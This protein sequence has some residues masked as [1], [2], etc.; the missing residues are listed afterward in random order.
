MTHNTLWIQPPL[1]ALCKALQHAKPTLWLCPTAHAANMAAQQTAALDVDAMLCPPNFFTPDDPKSL[2]LYGQQ[3]RA[4]QNRKAIVDGQT[5][6]GPLPPTTLPAL[7]ITVGMAQERLIAALEAANY[8]AVDLVRAP[9]TWSLRTT[10]IDLYNPCYPW[11]VRCELFDGEVEHIRY[12]NPNH[13][14]SLPESPTSFFLHTLAPPTLQHGWFAQR[15]RWITMDLDQLEDDTWPPEAVAQ[16]HNGDNLFTLSHPL[17]QCY[18]HSTLVGTSATL[19]TL[20]TTLTATLSTPP[21]VTLTKQRV[22]G[23]DAPYEPPRFELQKGDYAVHEQAGIGKYE[24]LV[25]HT[26]H[27]GKEREFLQLT[28]AQGATLYVP[29]SQSHLVTKYGDSQQPVV[30]EGI[31]SKNWKKKSARA[32]SAITKYAHTLIHTYAQRAHYGGLR[33]GK[34]DSESAAL[35]DRTR[36]FALTPDQATAIAAIG[37]DLASDVAMDRLLCGDVGYGKTE[38]AIAA[39][40]QACNAGKQV[41]FLAP[42]ALLAL[43]HYE[44]LLERL[45]PFPFK[46]AHLSKLAKHEQA[47]MAQIRAGAIDIVVGTH[48]LLHHFV[49]CPSLA[50]VIIDEEQRFGVKAKETFRQ[51][52]PHLHYLALSATP[53]PRTLRFAMSGVRTLSSLTTPPANR[54]PVSVFVQQ[55]NPDMIAQALLREKSRLGRSF[56][57]CNSIDHL[58]R[59]ARWCEEQGLTSVIAHGQMP[60]AQMERAF[61][62][63]AKGDVD[64]LIATTVIE[65]GIDIPQA[66][67]IIV[68]GAQRFGL[69]E[70]YQIKGRVGRSSH[71]G[72]AYFFTPPKI[73]PLAQERLDALIAASLHGGGMQIAL[74]DLQLRGAGDFLGERQ[75]GHMHTIGFPLY[76]QWLKREMAALKEDTSRTNPQVE[77]PQAAHFPHHYLPHGALRM[78]LYHRLGLCDTLTQVQQ[79]FEE[80]VDRFGALPLEAKWLFALTQFRL[81][82]QRKGYQSAKAYA[83]QGQ[84]IWHLE[85]AIGCSTIRKTH[86]TPPLTHPEQLLQFLTERL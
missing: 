42:T 74:S 54:Q 8:T 51:H 73:T 37:E 70:L 22:V 30:L 9:C 29:V 68:E 61:H 76:C 31:A 7:P 43:Q 1:A 75:S 39:C 12:F 24:G 66:N 10:I 49:H 57:L 44:R 27:T 65:H 38:V 20:G 28:F 5:L 85:R 35:L 32:H 72:Y 23:G 18:A 55:H 58:P 19:P 36:P 56:Y 50:L 25:W 14:K 59:K 84:W 34:L 60:P 69:A 3:Y 33:L 17:S 53:I 67:T 15:W 41:V 63:F 86:T 40:I 82:V 26:D 47:T 52:H 45:Q 16:L 80:V 48:R 77:I 13:Q 78:E 4:L 83:K 11:P 64:V 2:L 21:P 6:F 46:I 62:S 71:Q 79:L 81:K